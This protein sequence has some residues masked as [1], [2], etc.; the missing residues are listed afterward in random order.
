MRLNSDSVCEQVHN[1]RVGKVIK[2]AEAQGTYGVKPAPQIETSFS[3]KV[4]AQVH[5]T[6]YYGGASGGIVASRTTYCSRAGFVRPIAN[7]LAVSEVRNTS[8]SQQFID[9]ANSTIRNELA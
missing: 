2:A 3:L 4:L 8:Y 6:L 9:S 5:N 1:A 7:K